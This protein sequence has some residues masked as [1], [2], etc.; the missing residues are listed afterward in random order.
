[1]RPLLGT[2][3]VLL[4][5]LSLPAAADEPA[6]EIPRAEAVRSADGAWLMTL[7]PPMDWIAAEVSVKGSDGVDLGPASAAV[8]V[9]VQG[10]SAKDGPLLVTLQVATSDHIGITWEFEVEPIS[11]PARAPALQR[12]G[13]KKRWG[14]K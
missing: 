4:P 6:P 9:Q 8:P 1:M 13:G 2:L 11:V 5:A 12:D 10:F 14:R 3:V 7:T